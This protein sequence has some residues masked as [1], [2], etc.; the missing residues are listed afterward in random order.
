MHSA[1]PFVR[2]LL[3]ALIVFTLT[4]A[5][6]ATL[7]LPEG[8]AV[9]PPE[10]VDLT[11]QAITLAGENKEVLAAWDGD[12][13][14]YFIR[15]ELPPP[16]LLNAEAY[17][18]GLVS[19]L[20]ASGANVEIGKRSDYPITSGLQGS[21]LVV[22]TQSP[23][24]PRFD[25]TVVHF[26]TNGKVAFIAVARLTAVSSAE[27]LIEETVALFKTARIAVPEVP[28]GV[29]PSVGRP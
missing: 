29:R 13:L 24:Q 21:Y 19:D 16:G 26:I 2:T 4:A 6:A 25:H 12:T 20:R 17:Y 27:L 18:N 10:S 11:Q 23:S 15:V 1:L 8:L 7:V 9:D 14:R 28:E 5:S 3:A 22:K